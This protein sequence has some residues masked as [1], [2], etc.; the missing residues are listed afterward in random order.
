MIL[1]FFND[2]YHPH[3]GEFTSWG[4]VGNKPFYVN[5]YFKKDSDRVSN[6][7]I[8]CFLRICPL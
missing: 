1:L 8:Q 2:F 3:E 4:K 7:K 6:L 5:A